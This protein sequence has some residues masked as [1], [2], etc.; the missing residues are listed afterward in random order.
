MKSDVFFSKLIATA[1]GAG[2]WPWGPGTA[3]ALLGMAVWGVMF[4]VL[5]PLTLLATM[6]V[7]IVVF[8]ALGTWATAKLIPEWG[9]DPQRVVIDEVVGV[10]IALLGASGWLSA[11]AALVLFRFFDIVKPLG[12]R[13]LDRRKGAFWVMADDILAGVYALACICILYFAEVFLFSF[14]D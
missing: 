12:I 14:V 1:C 13:A 3:G 8:T 4:V 5:Q 2:Y 11:V 7:L 9:D 6:G 10:W